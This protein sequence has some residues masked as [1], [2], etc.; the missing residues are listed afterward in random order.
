[1]SCGAVFLPALENN[2]RPSIVWAILKTKKQGVSRA[3]GRAPV[4]GS[5]SGV[6]GLIRR[7][8]RDNYRHNVQFLGIDTLPNAQDFGRIGHD[9]AAGPA[10][11]G[12][13]VYE[14]PVGS[15]GAIVAPDA[16]A[17]IDSF[18]LTTVETISFV[19]HACGGAYI[20]SGIDLQSRVPP[21]LR[22]NLHLTAFKSER[23]IIVTPQD[24]NRKR[25]SIIGIIG[26]RHSLPRSV[27]VRFWLDQISA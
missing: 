17:E 22:V 26:I 4:T 5:F 24:I 10:R 3:A 9:T 6:P 23:P 11:S 25:H 27:C 18:P 19:G 12:A 13:F 16:L 15:P 14:D 8:V 2:Q 7:L 21:A 20:G 1:M